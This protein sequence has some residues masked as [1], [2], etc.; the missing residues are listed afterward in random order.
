MTKCNAKLKKDYTGYRTQI[1][2]IID[3]Q[4]D[5]GIDKYGVKLEDNNALNNDERINHLMEELVD[6]L[7]YSLKI[8]DNQG[9]AFNEYQ[10]LAQR[11]QNREA[12]VQN[13][14]LEAAIGLCEESGEVAG[15]LKKFLFHE[16]DYPREAIIKE[17]GD[18]LWYLTA[19]AV[20]FNS[21][22]E[23]VAKENI[24]KLETRYPE[25]F[26]AEKSIN[27]T[28]NDIQCL[29]AWQRLSKTCDECSEKTRCFIKSTR[30]D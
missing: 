23:E 30:R 17:L 6:G 20:E 13:R 4:I 1:I 24:E 9:L 29:G 21:S 11:T 16:H 8:K 26:S 2:D 27:R 10:A 15:K 7:F 25:G 28:E 14:M 19:L 5:K 3:R 22:L 12:P 18:V